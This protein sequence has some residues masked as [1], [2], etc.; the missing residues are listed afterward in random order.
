M[1][2]DYRSTSMHEGAHATLIA[3]YD[4][5]RPG[6]RV[7]M[8]D[9]PKQ[10]SERYAGTVLPA[11]R[12]PTDPNPPTP[13]GVLHLGAK[14]DPVLR[15]NAARSA[16]CDAAGVWGEFH[17]TRDWSAAHSRSSTNDR[18]NARIEFHQIGYDPVDPWPS[19]NFA[20]IEMV[21]RNFGQI[22]AVS[23]ALIERRELSEIDV[24]EI[25]ASA[26]THRNPH[27]SQAPIWRE[28]EPDEFVAESLLAWRRGD[29][30]ER[31]ERAAA[32][33]DVNL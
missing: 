8:N 18:Q 10:L 28:I 16:I 13:K 15:L 14:L 6:W 2:F 4:Q 24:R 30:I 32:K 7:L 22:K 20:A 3:L 26:P 27:R 1:K 9:C 33:V 5:W 31:A 23:A 19:L 11:G 29:W 21:D 25:V 12:M 17:K